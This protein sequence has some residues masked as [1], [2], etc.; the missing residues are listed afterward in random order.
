[1]IRYDSKST[2]AGSGAPSFLES[3]NR[4][5][6]ARSAGMHPD[7]WYPAEKSERL[8]RGKALGI[9]FWGRS[10]AIFRDHNGQVHAVED[11]C[12]HRQ[13][14]L[15]LGQVKGCN[16]VCMYHGWEFD[17]DGKLVNIPHE[18][19]NKPFPQIRIGSF[20][21][22]ERY[23]LIWI[24]PGNPELKDVHR[25]PDIPELEGADQWGLVSID[26]KWRGHHSMVLDNVSDFTHAYL[27]RKYKPFS[28]AKLT[29]LETIGDRVHLSYDTKVGRGRIAQYFVNRREVD[30]DK[31][32][33]CYEYPYQWSNI[34]NKIKHHCFVLPMDEK[35]THA[36]FLFYFKKL[37][38]PV[39]NLTIPHGVLNKVLAVANKLHI[40][41][42]IMEDGVAVA[43]EQEGY[44][45]HYD[46]PIAELSPAVAQFQQLTIRKWEEYLATRG[47]EKTVPL[48]QL[49][50]H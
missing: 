48:T 27:H 15:S 20:P 37:V 36:F 31:M 33:L 23:G 30:T 12:A 22:Q 43:A 39:V 45:E 17:A 28:D 24:F 21:V 49:R 42:L 10:I 1:M 2:T 32:D 19:F 5:Q 9:K 34:D 16:L 8:K 13:V 41:P 3:K 38:V 46:A 50:A 6:K 40:T 35:F 14:K 26:F 44:D 11:R 25:L 4:R 29:K 18:L 47:A 7:Y